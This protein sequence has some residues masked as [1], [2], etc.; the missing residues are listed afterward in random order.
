[1]KANKKVVLIALVTLLVLSTILMVY[2]ET[3]T[4]PEEKEAVPFFRRIASAGY[5]QKCFGVIDEETTVEIKE[6]YKEKTQNRVPLFDELVNEGLITSKQKEN[7]EEYL[8]NKREERQ[9][10]LD[11]LLDNGVITQEQKDT[12]IECRDQV[13]QR[14][15]DAAANRLLDVLYD[16][17][18]VTEEEADRIAE[19]LD[20]N[21]DVIKDG[22][23][24][25]VL[26]DEKL[27]SADQASQIRELR[28]DFTQRMVDMK[29]RLIRRHK[30]A[31]ALR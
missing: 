13:H 16:K 12:I 3:N 5:W 18:I 2:A 1:M 10:P 22:N 17:G 21:P 8:E 15:I 29:E 20:E 31:R 14:M 23:I 4:D 26:I 30:A 9:N 25:Q 6:F 24:I 7:I 19:Y 28:N 27:L 11:E